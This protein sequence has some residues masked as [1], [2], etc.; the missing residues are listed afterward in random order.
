MVRIN[1]EQALRCGNYRCSNSFFS[2]VAV[3]RDD[4]T[5]PL[6]PYLEPIIS[7]D[8]CPPNCSCFQLD[9]F[10]IDKILEMDIDTFLDEMFTYKNYMCETEIIHLKV[11]QIRNIKKSLANEFEYFM[12]RYRNEFEYFKKSHAPSIEF[13][14]NKYGALWHRVKCDSDSIIQKL[15][16]TP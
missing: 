6:T 3:R 4:P 16:P 2:W 14:E 8:T 10:D 13:Y 7:P 5:D 15:F 11:E 1:E 12:E 9:E